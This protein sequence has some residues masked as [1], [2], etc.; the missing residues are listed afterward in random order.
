MICQETAGFEN[1]FSHTNQEQENHLDNIVDAPC[2]EDD[3]DNE[4]EEVE[5]RPYQQPTKTQEEPITGQRRQMTAKIAHSLLSSDNE[6]ESEDEQEEDVGPPV[7]HDVENHRQTLDN[8]EEDDQDK[9]VSDDED[10]VINENSKDNPLE[11]PLYLEHN[12]LRFTEDDKALLRLAILLRNA[13]CPKFMFDAILAWIDSTKESCGS[14]FFN[15]KHP[16]RKGFMAKL[17][18]RG[19]DFPNPKIVTTPMEFTTKKNIFVPESEKSVDTVI[20]DFVQQLQ[21]VLQ[22]PEATSKDKTILYDDDPYRPYKP[23]KHLENIQDGHVFQRNVRKY[24]YDSDAFVVG[25]LSYMDKTH[26]TGDGSFNA[27]PVVIVPSFLKMSEMQKPNRQI[28]LGLITDMERKSSA[29][30]YI[31]PTIP[32]PFVLVAVKPLKHS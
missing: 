28:I 4:E 22:D 16:R 3:E 8:E 30:K 27:E 9:S 18:K 19:F 20:F 31:Y 32:D 21:R 15:K 7:G 13:G 17:E 1:D 29:A 24:R 10:H 23:N 11:F 2:V 14:Q 25:L 26:A 12:G 6:E 5:E